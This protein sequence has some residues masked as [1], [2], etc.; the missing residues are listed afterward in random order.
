[1]G[2]DSCSLKLSTKRDS[3]LIGDYFGW[4]RRSK[5]PDGIVSFEAILVIVL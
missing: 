2:H 5:Y 1:M 3:G 4:E